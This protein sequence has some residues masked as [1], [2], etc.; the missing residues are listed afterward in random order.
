MQWLTAVGEEH[1]LALLSVGDYSSEAMGGGDGTRRE[2]V[3][4]MG[5]KVGPWEDCIVDGG[6]KRDS[7][8]TLDQQKE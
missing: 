8:N 3:W 2:W 4:V 6:G 1:R 5:V 7:K